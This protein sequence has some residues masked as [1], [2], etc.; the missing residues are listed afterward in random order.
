MSLYNKIIDLQ[1][2]NAAWNKVRKNK[3]ACGVDNITWEQFDANKENELKKMYVELK[4]HTYKP[5]P[6]RKQIIYEREHARESVLYSMR[7]KVVQQS[8]AAELDRIFE[9]QFPVQA[10]AYRK[11]KSALIA[12]D[13]LVGQLVSGNWKI[14]L[15]LDIEHFFDHI[16][17]QILKEIL[18]QTIYETDVLDLIE[19][20]IKTAVLC[21]D[22][23]LKEPQIGIHQGSALSPVLSNIYLME[24]DHWLA[25]RNCYFVRYSDDLLLL[26]ENRE[27]VITLLG[28]IRT[29]LR[30]YGLE[31]NDEKMV[32]S[33]C[34][35]G[36]D[37]LGY[38]I[39]SSGKGIPKKAE[40]SIRQRVEWMWLTSS[41]LTIEEKIKKATEIIGGWKQ[42]F[43][44]ERKDIS[45]FEYVVLVKMTTDFT[46]QE[47]ME[48]LKA[49]R[50][51]V[52][53]IYKD[54]MLYLVD[55]WKRINDTSMELL[56]YEQYYQ[57]WEMGGSLSQNEE[58][59]L[60]G[61]YRELII[62]EKEDCI[63]ELMQVYTDLRQYRKAAYWMRKR[64]E[65]ET[66]ESGKGISMCLPVSEQQE[67]LYDKGTPQ[68]LL[69]LLAGREDMYGIETINSDRRRQVELQAKPLTEEILQEHLSGEFT[70]ATYIQR[71]NSTVKYLV[72][73]I[74][75]SK[76]VILKYEKGT[77]EFQ[78]Y[79]EKA[80]QK[81]QELVKQLLRFGMQSY[82]ENSGYRGYHVW[83]FFEEWVQVRYVNMFCD[84]LLKNITIEE[85][86][87]FEFFPNKTRIK[88]GKFGQ[89]LKLPCGFHLVTGERSCF[90]DEDGKVVTDLN[91]FLDSIAKISLNTVKKVLA[92]NIGLKEP[93]EERVV[94]RNL[95]A[96]ENIPDTIQEILK[97]CNLMR[98]LCQKSRKTGYLTHFERLS[99]LYVFGHLGEEGKQFVHQIMEFTL[100]YQYHITEKFIRK[101]PE[102]PIS[103]VK[104]R[105]QYKSLTAEFGCS[106]S[107]KRT[108]NCYPSP[109][110]HA[111]ARSNDIQTDITLPI[112]RSMPKDR[113]K[114]V[115]E[116]M[117][118]HKKVQ[119]LAQRM[120]ALK[121]QKRKLGAAIAKVEQELED[122]YDAAE[123]EFL[124]IELG[125]LIRRKTGERYDWVIEL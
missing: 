103:C 27:G 87:N 51:R 23:E 80:Y 97:N 9:N 104:L 112:S 119:E 10:Y 107:F 116:E 18:I 40:Q 52:H 35:V 42:Y 17:W 86:I 102:K 95:E 47:Q 60:L 99:V 48:K 49:M 21:D 44:E 98:Y 69:N 117:N 32:C 123:I 50:R 5:L 37:F 121:R 15:K 75:V 39:S 83:I 31:L 73:D 14:I 71:P 38:H 11:D 77:R 74:D 26:G 113:K 63:T 110:L 8:I 54:I 34:E 57:I 106:C 28:E 3:P 41:E 122:I 96:F 67:V 114:E 78:I 66:L 19:K 65:Y 53:N 13:K 62:A 109:V 59:L 61:H 101:I 2:L 20:N 45:I 111:I 81:A 115:I 120:I 85:N 46:N 68:R 16:Q 76:K 29:M 118:I 84:V 94:D 22:G 55:V 124:E 89:A 58:L 91:L 105:E 79:L 24:F 7:D 72:I 1:K 82:I 6:V 90:I 25:T 43:R 93:L 30:K 4:E 56:E 92:A 70:V 88:P 36:V 108:K 12:I 100:N 33:D 64:E 125:I